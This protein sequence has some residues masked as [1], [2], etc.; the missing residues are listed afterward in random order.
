[1][2]TLPSGLA[3]K[4]TA[5]GQQ[6]EISVT[7]QD[8]V[9]KLTLFAQATYPAGPSAA[10]LST[11]GKILRARIANSGATTGPLYLQSITPA[12][13]T[14]W[15]A[16]GTLLSSAAVVSAGAAIAQ[17]AGT[18]RCFYQRASDSF[19]VYR[20]STDDGLTWGAETSLLAV[21]LPYCTGIT[22]SSTT[23]VWIAAY[24][25]PTA[26]SLLY[27]SAYT[28]SWS[29]WSNEGP[30]SPTWG[31]L[32]GLNS[33]TVAGTT[34]V[35]AGVA[36]RAYVSG[37]SASSFT[38]AGTTYSGMAYIQ[39]L[40][41]PAAGLTCA[42]PDIFYDGSSFYAVVTLTDDGSVSTSGHTRTAIYT[43]SDGLTWQP[44]LAAGSVLQ[45]GAHLIKTGGTTYVFDAVT[46]YTVPSPP[47]AIDLSDD[48]LA[49]HITE[50]F[51]RP[52]TLALELSNNTGQYTAAPWL[53]DNVTLTV[54]LGYGGQLVQTHTFYLDDW[55]LT[56][57]AADQTLTLAA[58]DYLKLMDYPSTGLI[59]YTGQT[60]TQILTD[61]AKKAQ[62][63]IGSPPATPQFSQT[64]GCFLINQG[65]TFLAALNR[66]ANVFGF[67]VAAGGGPSVFLFD[68]QVT[69]GST[70]TYG[71]EILGAG[72]GQ[73]ADA[74]NVIRVTGAAAATATAP[75][76]AEVTDAADILAR[77]MER[78]RNVVDRILTTSAQ[79][80]I[81]AQQEL[82]AEQ[83]TKVHAALTVALNPA[84]Q[85]GDVIAVTDTGCGMS[86]TA[87]RIS[88][89]QWIA[90]PTTGAWE[91]H[92]TLE[93]P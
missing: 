10:V 87:Y 53:S 48:V 13:P 39:Q 93:A 68:P 3:T 41:S 1:M 6:P 22:A 60:T 57:T 58:R 16:T 64:I 38:Y 17:T 89:M 76:W 55:Q 69:D 90:D 15:T 79:C 2:R 25:Y 78:Y 21:P 44:Y 50:T 27:R 9:T 54:S 61:L 52:S 4:I 30:P 23:Q 73:E 74:A 31:L 62:V 77:G 46:C 59:T 71:T 65:E 24:V 11:T 82:R 83:R 5:S 49:L 43:S 37:I 28:T 85:L 40:D 92:L 51:N 56:S 45:G 67:I 29:A 66:L 86:G 91:H 81:R 36:M 14:S 35:A 33:T 18:T 42:D 75:A 80:L 72:R 63:T 12:S 26:A 88:G 20:D 8:L 70:W 34:Y 84:H 19:I 47:A 7:V 32:E